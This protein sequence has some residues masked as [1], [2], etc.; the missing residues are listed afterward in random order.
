[1]EAAYKAKPGIIATIAVLAAL[2]GISMVF[3]QAYTPLLL[4]A[5]FVGALVILADPLWGIC[6]TAIALPFVSNEILIVLM[7][8][9]I[10]SY[11]FRVVRKKELDFAHTPLNLPIIIFIV[12]EILTT[13]F[14]V[15]PMLS[16]RNLLVEILSFGF[17]FVMINT[18]NTRTKLNAA[19]KV[20][21]IVTVAMS[22]LGIVQYFTIGPMNKLWADKKLH[23][24]LAARTVGTFGNPNIF[25]EYIEHM[26]PV[27][28]AL[29][30]GFRK[31]KNKLAAAAMF[32]IM[33][34]CLVLTFS[35]ASWL[36]FAAAIGLFFVVKLARFI[37]VL[38]AA[39]VAAI[40]FLPN[41]VLQRIHSIGS[42][43]DSSNAY[44]M[45]VW[46]GTVKMIKDFWIT[47]VGFGYWAFKNSYLS[48]SIKGTRVWHAHNLF[49]E[50]SAEMGIFGILVFLW[51]MLL[52][53]KTSYC[54]IQSSK[55]KYLGYLSLG[56]S[57]AVIS[58]LVHG[59]GEHI[60]YMPK[61][62]LMFW[63][64]VAFQMAVIGIGRKKSEEPLGSCSNE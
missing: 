44:R 17:F 13:I 33:S 41:V 55:D 49:L 10:A 50:I 8:L 6:A 54:F 29:V 5:A 64:V 48:Y 31:F 2:A 53:F 51:I 15:D 40:P 22:M 43:K 36:G 18:L 12:V 42:L 38:F 20:F 62:V 39:G 61:S 34:V 30:F 57:C 52:M 21:L 58:L 7:T 16:A 60:L 25:A 45:M 56:L 1:M 63:M 59:V 9:V 46:Q 4:I 35:R 47:G 23:P 32:I 14:S 11:I 24:D 19:L 3:M 37:P 26:L 27:G 28:L